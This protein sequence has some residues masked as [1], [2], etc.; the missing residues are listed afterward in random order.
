MKDFKELKERYDQVRAQIL[1]WYEDKPE[2]KSFVVEGERHSV[3]VSE[4]SKARKIRSMPK[5]FKRLGQKLFLQLCTFALKYV[6]EHAPL[7]ER[8]AY[9]SEAQTGPRTLKCVVKLPS[10]A[11]RLGV[12]LAKAS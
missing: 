5:L 9:L 3:V 12:P 7:T 4:R 2:E 10:S 8:P 1:S 11:R 6:D